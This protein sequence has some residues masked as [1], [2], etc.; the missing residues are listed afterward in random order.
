MKRL[1]QITYKPAASKPAVTESI[2]IQNF[3]AN[4][5]D[6]SI[7][8]QLFLDK[9]SNKPVV[10]TNR[11]GIKQYQVSVYGTEAYAYIPVNAM[12]ALKVMGLA[13]TMPNGQVWVQLPLVSMVPSM[14]D[15]NSAPAYK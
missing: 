4:H 2:W 9:N 7:L 15:F 5:T 6:S 12:K 1:S 14:D 11:D 8:M 3:P 10:N 13:R